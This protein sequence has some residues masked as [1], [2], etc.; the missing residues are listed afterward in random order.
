MRPFK[1]ISLGTRTLSLFISL[2]NHSLCSLCGRHHRTRQVVPLALARRAAATAT[3]CATGHLAW[4]TS[5]RRGR[6]DCRLR[7]FG[8]VV[9]PASTTTNAVSSASCRYCPHA[10]PAA[11]DL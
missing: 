7:L 10:T 4:L 1:T 11:A 8:I 5:Q 6:R 9:R 2:L 3:T